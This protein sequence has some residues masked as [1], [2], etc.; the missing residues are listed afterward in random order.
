MPV[1]PRLPRLALLLTLLGGCVQHH[2]MTACQGPYTA[3]GPPAPPA[4]A[5][6]AA[7][8][9]MLEPAGGTKPK[10]QTTEAP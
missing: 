8:P 10:L 2:E 5:A 9:A 7:L 1:S 3:L 6:P 4:V